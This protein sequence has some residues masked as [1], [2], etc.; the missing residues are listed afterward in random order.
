MIQSDSKMFT[1]AGEFNQQ[2]LHTGTCD[3]H[4]CTLHP[5]MYQIITHTSHY[6]APL[7][8]LTSKVVAFH[9]DTTCQSAFEQLKVELTKTYVLAFPDFSQEA[10]PFHLQTDASAVGINAVLEQDGHVIAYASRVL[11][12]AMQEYSFTKQYQK[13]TDN[14]NADALSRQSQP[15]SHSK[16]SAVS[17]TNREDIRQN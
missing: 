3:M 2:Q 1:T 12:L 9:W 10:V 6:T 8:H 5:I 15:D 13:G 7:H 14:G 17:A 11:S 4:T 16:V